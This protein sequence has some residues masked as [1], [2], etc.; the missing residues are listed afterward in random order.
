MSARASVAAAGFGVAAA[1]WRSAA[2]G[3]GFWRLLALFAA[4]GASF[5]AASFAGGDWRPDG[6]SEICAD[7]PDA[8]IRPADAIAIGRRSFIPASSLFGPRF[9][10]C[11]ACACLIA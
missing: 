9:S 4:F 2:G 8:S 6:V 11:R 3:F 1:F 5:F 7:A 10:E